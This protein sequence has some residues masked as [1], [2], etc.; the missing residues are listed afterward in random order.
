[1]REHAAVPS[2][3][4]PVP[5]LAAEMGFNGT[6]SGQFLFP[7][8]FYTFQTVVPFSGDTVEFIMID[9][10]SRIGGLN[11][12]PE[13]LPSLYF[14]PPAPSGYAASGPAAAT[15]TPAASAST[16]SAATYTPTYA[17]PVASTKASYATAPVASATPAYSAASAPNAATAAAPMA[18]ATVAA[19][20]PTTAPYATASGPASGPASAASVYGRRRRLNQVVKMA[21]EK[22]LNDPGLD[23]AYE[24]YVAPSIN[25]AQWNWVEAAINSS[26]ADWI[27]VVG[28]HPVW[29]AGE[30][31]PTWPLVDRLGPMMEAAGVALYIGGLDHQMAHF[32]PVPSTNNVDYIV[33]GNGAYYNDSASSMNAHA[34]D[35]PYGGLQFQYGSGTGFA[36]L[37]VSH[38]DANVPGLLKVTFYDSSGDVLYDFYK[39]NPRTAAGHVVG[40]LGAPPSPSPL[41]ANADSGGPMVIVSSIFIVLGVSMGLWIIASHALTSMGYRSVRGAAYGAGGLSENTPLVPG[42]GG[43]LHG[44]VNL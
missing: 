11:P 6:N 16:Y 32:K 21:V 39:E 3:T 2:L 14:P 19:S 40:N 42:G 12:Q 33:V 13:S 34:S 25:E 20:A 23:A 5:A 9:T 22:G 15:A 44:V 8:L 36:Q 30:W 43:G 27:I 17:T 24:G 35:C 1:M 18:A 7:D 29:S 41:N 28:N 31:G 26:Y 37:K 4:R 38:T 10:M